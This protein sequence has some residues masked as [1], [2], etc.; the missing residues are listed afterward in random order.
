M[1]WSDEDRRFL[2]EA[3]AIAERG[4]GGTSPNPLVGAVVVRDGRIVG[5]GYH[6]RCGGPHAER[7]A[8]DEAGKLA[9]GA[10]L[11]VTLEPCSVHGRTPPC[12]ER[13]VSAG[14][15]RVVAPCCDPN[16][17]VDGRGFETLRLAGVEVDAGLL[18]EL[19][20]DQNAPYMTY[21]RTGR[22]YVRLKLACS[23][24]GRIAGPSSGPR[25]ISCPESL[26][27]V[28]TLRSRVDGVL[29]GIGTALADDPM[30]TDR[31]DGR[32]GRQPRR[33]VLD[34]EARL[35]TDSALVRTAGEVPTHVVCA[36]DAD[37]A[38]RS[39]LERLGVATIPAPR[40]PDGVDPRAALER[41]AAR[42]TLDL[43][44][45]GGSSLATSLLA[46]RLVDRLTLYIAPRLLG[47]RGTPS[48]TQLPVEG[49]AD[50]SCMRRV[51]WT[52]TGRDIRFEADL[53]AAAPAD[54]P[55]AAFDRE[56][57]SCSRG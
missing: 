50:G 22:P 16:P 19:A 52:Q 49:L 43:L 54:G 38:R 23:L 30:L 13:I 25:A 47:E 56:R 46:R 4:R 24:D 12:T 2:R 55:D 45:E 57:S 20:A 7:V 51:T 27:E 26:E 10:A 21:R 17:E 37:A 1:T 8:L 36:D 18:R 53:A 29:V 9:R 15:R 39:E 28:H 41:I 48:F 5:R 11:Y 42:G 34:T 6:E 31:R 35:A 44:C 33:F 32:P 14:I 40:G 3:F